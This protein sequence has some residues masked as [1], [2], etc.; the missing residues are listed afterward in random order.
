M[1]DDR[2]QVD[3]YIGGMH[4]RGLMPSR[5][6]DTFGLAV[7]HASIS[8]DLYAAKEIDSHETAV[9]LTYRAQVFPWLAIQPG[10]Q[11]IPNPRADSSL[12]KAV[13]SLLRFQINL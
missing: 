1:P 10:V 11:I 4:Y 2:N 8:D 13:V 6:D 7:A 3:L 12:D 5:E 9:E